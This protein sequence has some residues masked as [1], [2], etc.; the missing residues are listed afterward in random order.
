MDAQSARPGRGFTLVELLVVIA[1]IGVLV[2]LLLPAVQAARESARRSQCQ[3]QLK[4]IGI[5]MHLFHDAMSTLPPSRLP[6]HHGTWASLLWPYLEEGAVAQRWDKQRSYHFQPAPNTEVQ[7][8]LYLCPSRRAAP[9]LSVSGD[10]RG[11]VKH[12]PGGLSDYAVSIGDGVDYDGDGGGDQHEG[13]V[14]P[15]GA[16]R[17]GR[18]ECLGFDPDF[19]FAGVYKSIISFR[20]ITDG[21]SKTLFVGEKHLTEPCFGRESGVDPATGLD[22]RC[23]DNSVYNGDQHRTIARYAGPSSPLADS[24]STPLIEEK[25]QFGS[26][27]PGICH[28]LLGDGSVR[29][30]SNDTSTVVLGRLANIA[31]GELLDLG[32]FN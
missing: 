12:R 13:A 18:G 16:F 3:S 15:N 22:I 7:V 2:A 24:P 11:A 6:C 27:H 19:R 9:Q 5:A 31:D 28:G 32:S 30:G 29:S 10:K 14:V 17:H 1:I 8:S 26:W 4:Q 21:L 23:G 25:S 20:K